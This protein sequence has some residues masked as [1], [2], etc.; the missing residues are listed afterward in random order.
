MHELSITM[1]IL[2]IVEENARNL[3]AKI[4]HEIEMDIGELSGVDFD[5]LEFAVEHAQKPAIMQDV[6]FVI[7]K[8][9]AKAKCNN[10]N[11]EFELNDY[12]TPCPICNNFDHDIFQGKELK[13]KSIKID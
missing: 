5:A 12:Y 1:S 2:E 10:C 13:V 8:I 7:N 9:Q 3:N 4:V 11:Y 6:K